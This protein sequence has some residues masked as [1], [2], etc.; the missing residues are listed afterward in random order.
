[1]TEE[2][3]IDKFPC[4]SISKLDDSQYELAQPFLIER[5]IE[6]IEFEFRT[7]LNGKQ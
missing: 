2:G 6:F 4:I 5:I 7:E 1:M 3:S